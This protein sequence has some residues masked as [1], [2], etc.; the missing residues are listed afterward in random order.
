MLV[1]LI[2]ATTF[3]RKLKETHLGILFDQKNTND[4]GSPHSCFRQQVSGHRKNNF[5]NDC[6]PTFTP[7]LITGI[8]LPWPAWKMKEWGIPSAA[9][10]SLPKIY[11]IT[12]NEW[13][14]IFSCHLGTGCTSQQPI[15]FNLWS[16]KVERVKCR[17]RVFENCIA[18]FHVSLHS[19]HN[20]IHFSSNLY[21][22]VI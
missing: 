10:S 14:T 6:T 7:E 8:A 17:I 15:Y 13:S 2:V 1:L 11:I 21:F 19:H 20:C 4:H 22:F 3:A 18:L 12:L 9:R 16:Y 5:C